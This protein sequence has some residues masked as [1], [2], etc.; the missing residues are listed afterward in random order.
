MAL[1]LKSGISLIGIQPQ[2][3]LA[4]IVAEGV[5]AEEGKDCVVT[6]G[7]EKARGRVARSH[8]YKGLAPDFRTSVLPVGRRQAVADEI[9]RRLGRDFQVVLKNNHIHCEYDPTR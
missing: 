8:H 7:T 3:V 2:F 9:Q 5:Y 6:S 4:C 1:V